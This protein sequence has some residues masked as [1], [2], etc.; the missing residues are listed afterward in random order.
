MTALS[1]MVEGPIRRPLQPRAAKPLR[2]PAMKL[3]HGAGARPAGH[4]RSALEHG[5]SRCH[6]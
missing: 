1:E 3:A 6:A 2:R 4:A 5:K